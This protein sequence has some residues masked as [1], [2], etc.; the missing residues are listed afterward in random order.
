MSTHKK[1]L[2]N[3]LTGS[4]KDDLKKLPQYQKKLINQ[5]VKVNSLV[6]KYKFD[7]ID[8]EQLVN[9]LHDIHKEGLKGM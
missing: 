6:E 2:T 5:T 8:F 7:V 3:I 1:A 9:G 4:W